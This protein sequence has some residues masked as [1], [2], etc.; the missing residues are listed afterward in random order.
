MRMKRHCCCSEQL[1]TAGDAFV[2]FLH[3]FPLRCHWS[4]VRCPSVPLPK[5]VVS[6]VRPFCQA[7]LCHPPRPSRRKATHSLLRVSRA[8]SVAL[9][10][11]AETGTGSFDQTK[12]WMREIGSHGKDFPALSHTISSQFFLRLSF[13]HPPPPAGQRPAEI[14]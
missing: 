13:Y 3:N 10:L 14:F 7:H 8:D 9:F 4:V 6:V 1:L 2:A 12:E 5:F 11:I